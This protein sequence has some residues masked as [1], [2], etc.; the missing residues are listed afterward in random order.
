M[1]QSRP[2]LNLAVVRGTVARSA[3]RRE[4][5]DGSVVQFDLVTRLDA[6]RCD[7]PVAWFDPPGDPEALLVE[8]ASVVVVGR[9]VR[10]FF[11]AGGVTQSRTELVA[12]QVVPAS[13]SRSVRS[14]AARAAGALD[15]R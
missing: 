10:R 6:G 7:V 14:A 4:L 8:G 15:A 5:A 12:A 2:D 11:R 1:S 13:R 3:E 9:V